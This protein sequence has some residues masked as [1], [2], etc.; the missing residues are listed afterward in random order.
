[1]VNGVAAAGLEFCRPATVS[2]R[3][4]AY[5][6]RKQRA[7]R[8]RISRRKRA[9]YEPIEMPKKQRDRFRHR[10]LCRRHRLCADLAHLVDG[11]VWEYSAH[12]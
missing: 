1:M 4:T 8:R 9:E 6:S 7:Q 2:L 10:V 11:R 12:S 3:E 5:W